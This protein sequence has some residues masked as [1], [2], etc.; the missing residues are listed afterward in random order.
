MLDSLDVA[1]PTVSNAEDACYPAIDED[2]P[3]GWGRFG[4]CDPP[5]QPGVIFGWGRFFEVCSACDAATIQP[6]CKPLVCEEDADCPVF[7]NSGRNGPFTEEF[8]CRNGLC[9]SSDLE[10]HPVDVLSPL[11]GMLLCAAN[12]ERDEIYDGPDPC[13]GVEPFS[14]EACP[15][16]LPDTCLQP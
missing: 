5:D 1:Y 3:T 6:L 7:E 12:H 16:P 9:Q 13:P 8:E 14:G 15:L 10:G 11:D 4:R 2:T